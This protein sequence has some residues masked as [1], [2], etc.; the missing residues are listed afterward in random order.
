MKADTGSAS[1]P[2][3]PH[4]SR[5]TAT[6]RDFKVADP[7][8]AGVDGLDTLLDPLDYLGESERL[9]R[10]VLRRRPG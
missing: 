5:L 3:T 9:V 7:A 2:F 6:E 10:A 1:Q 4:A 8:L